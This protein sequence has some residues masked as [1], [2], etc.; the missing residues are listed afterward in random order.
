M[1]PPDK[2]Q[3]SIRLRL[4]WGE[5]RNFLVSAANP[6]NPVF[7]S[8]ARG[9]DWTSCE[10]SVARTYCDLILGKPLHV[11]DLAPGTKVTENVLDALRAKAAAEFE[12]IQDE[13]YADL[14]N[15][16]RAAYVMSPEGEME[17]ISVRFLSGRGEASG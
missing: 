16:G 14:A 10:S 17:A 15:H 2:P 13:F 9:V 5:D 11:A 7:E 12:R 6:R 4:P 8:K 1:F 3:D